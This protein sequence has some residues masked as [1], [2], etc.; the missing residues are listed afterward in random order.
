MNFNGTPIF[1]HYLCYI[2]EQG[3]PDEKKTVYQQLHSYQNELIDAKCEM[4]TRQIIT[5]RNR[6]RKYDGAPIIK[7]P[8][9][10]TN[11]ET[12]KITFDP[13]FWYD[14]CFLWPM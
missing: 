4:L 11:D 6:E 1:Y 12:K 9:E 8:T 14:S 3:L 10:T 2:V 7:V 5:K 13:L